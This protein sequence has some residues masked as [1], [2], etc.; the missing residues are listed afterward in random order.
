L[1]GYV[2]GNIWQTNAY[3]LDDRN[4]KR[5]AFNWLISYMNSP[6]RPKPVSP[7]NVTGTPRNPLLIWHPY[8]TTATS[9]RV[10][11]SPSSA[12]TSF[13]LDTVVTDTLLQI[14][15]LSAS[16]RLYW[17]VSATSSTGTGEYS[18][19][20]S[21]V[22]GTQ[23]VSVSQSD[24][25]PVQYALFQ[26]YP[27]PFN[28]STVISYVIPKAAYV[29]LAV[30]NVLGQQ[31]ATLVDEEL[32]ANNYQFTWTPSR[33]SSGI[34]FYRILVRPQDNIAVFT[35]VKKLLLMK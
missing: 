33:L 26:N 27:N 24:T 17:R 5:P 11:L 30:Y 3:L 18:N 16:L 6:F 13:I 28:P 14:D 7:V 15:S 25:H 9:Y 35:D 31:V 34:Y 23:I 21:F 4:A 22:T 8:D 1:W 19:A 12:F 10:Q 20:V 32:R 29:H 2:Y